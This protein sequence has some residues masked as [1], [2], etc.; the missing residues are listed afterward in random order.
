MKNSF[1]YANINRRNKRRFLNNIL[2][3]L[4]ML[5]VPLSTSNNERDNGLNKVDEALNAWKSVPRGPAPSHPFNWLLWKYNSYLANEEINN[6]FLVAEWGKDAI[7][8][9]VTKEIFLSVVKINTVT[10]WVLTRRS[11]K[12]GVTENHIRQACLKAP[13]TELNDNKESN[14]V[15]FL[16]KWKE[17]NNSHLLNGLKGRKRAF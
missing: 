16:K 6:S 14:Q 8:L 9:Y 3:S 10:L 5:I 12:K 1:V 7:F 4:R 11:F 2:Q 15:W 17:T 13:F